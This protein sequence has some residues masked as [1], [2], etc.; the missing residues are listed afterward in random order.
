MKKISLCSALLI[1]ILPVFLQGMDQL[2]AIEKEIVRRSIKT[3]GLDRMRSALSEP[4]VQRGKIGF[5]IEE[6]FYKDQSTTDPLTKTIFDAI[7]EIEK[8]PKPASSLVYY[9]GSRTYYVRDTF[10][11]NTLEVRM[12]PKNI[13]ELNEICDSYKE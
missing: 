10:E 6:K 5:F 2:N 11:P 13:K 4:N 12:N 7:E 8:K 1:T 3:N 9:L